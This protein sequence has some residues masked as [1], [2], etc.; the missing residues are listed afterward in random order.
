M[1][2]GRN[3]PSLPQKQPSQQEPPSAEH[4]SYCIATDIL[5]HFPTPQNPLCSKHLQCKYFTEIANKN[6][7]LLLTSPYRKENTHVSICP[8]KSD[9][10]YWFTL[11]HFGDFHVSASE[12]SDNLCSNLNHLTAAPSSM[13]WAST[14]WEPLG[15]YSTILLIQSQGGLRAGHSYLCSSYVKQAP[16]RQ[17]GCAL[18]EYL[19]LLTDFQPCHW[20]YMKGFWQGRNSPPRQ[21]VVNPWGWP[22]ALPSVLWL[23]WLLS[24]CLHPSSCLREELLKFIAVLT[25]Q[26]ETCQAAYIFTTI[27]WALIPE[28]ALRQ[29]PWSQTVLC[30]CFLMCLDPFGALCKMH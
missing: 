18:N 21:F 3:L 30:H 12:W 8:M 19:N 13:N 4:L 10:L 24:Q 14:A 9:Q 17:A 26:L 23:C 20:S 7:F 16:K 5:K 27:V 28:G 11:S 15:F 6:S 29:D 2:L 25:H 1:Y 22:S